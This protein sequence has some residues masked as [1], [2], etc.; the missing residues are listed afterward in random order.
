MAPSKKAASDATTVSPDILTQLEELK[1]MVASYAT[2]FDKL[3]GPLKEVK[4]ENKKLRNDNKELKKHIEDRDKEITRLQ[5][6]FN[7]QEQYFRGWSVRILNVDIPEEEASMPTAIMRHV[8]DRV[9]HSILAGAKERGLI[10]VIPAAEE[11]LETA[12]LLPAKPG[13]IPPMICRFYTR[14]I[15]SLIFKLKKDFAPREESAMPAQQDKTDRFRQG[16]F[17]YPVYEDL[18]RVNFAKLRALAQHEKVH[19]CWTV[20]GSIRYKLKGE[21]T[22]RKVKSVSE[23][24]DKIIS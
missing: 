20:N 13:T 17:H 23:T 22:I 18:T 6:K 1:N 16:K 10:R 8:Y 4:E 15:Q 9:F 2:R 21:D 7:D 12:H 24:V 14:N 3:D 11:I 5:E 19:S